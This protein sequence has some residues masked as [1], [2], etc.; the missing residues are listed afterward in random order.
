MDRRRVG[1]KRWGR[2]GVGLRA[3]DGEWLLACH[4]RA[5]NTAHC[6]VRQAT[7]GPRFK[8]GGN[9]TRM[10]VGDL[11]AEGSLRQILD[12]FLVRDLAAS[13]KWSSRS[14]PVSQASTTLI[15]ESKPLS[16]L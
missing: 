5:S 11:Q 1:S 7:L 10:A 15:E 3:P 8:H 4:G 2:G 9:P 12:D 13:V 6:G 14:N 16:P